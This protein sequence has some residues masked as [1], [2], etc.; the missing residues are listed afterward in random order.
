[1]RRAEEALAVAAGAQVVSGTAI[2]RQ[3]GRIAL[4]TGATV[5]AGEVVIA[6]GAYA[7]MDALLPFRPAMQVYARTV[8]F[9][10]LEDG[11]AAALADMPTLI[12]V[13]DGETHDLYLL[14]PIRYPDGR[15][16]VKIGGEAESPLLET[17]ENLTRWFRSGGSRE[18]ARRLRDALARIV[19][20]LPLDRCTT[21]AC[22]VSFTAT[23]KPYIERLMPGL[24]LLTGGNGAGAKCADEIGRL[25]A[26][27]AKGE[28]LA[29]E[30]YGCAFR[31]VR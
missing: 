24:T 15:W 8:A 13:P 20:D 2:A 19:P 10:E 12:F 25:G 30:G 26:Q 18:A 29:L 6:T 16:L 22:A 14:P 3:G 11:E 4:A 5:N 28:D 9:V 23:G 27:V 21:G 31:C 17:A 1:M 7:A